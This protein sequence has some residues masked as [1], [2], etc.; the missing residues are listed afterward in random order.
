MGYLRERHGM[1]LLDRVPEGVCPACATDHEP[2]LP[3]N[4]QSLTYQ[5]KFYDEHGRWPTWDDAMSHCTDEVK[6]LWFEAMESVAR[7]AQP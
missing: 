7:E 2:E 5:Y 3:H 1:V 6:T 4:L